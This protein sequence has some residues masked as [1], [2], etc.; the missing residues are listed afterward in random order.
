MRGPE[1]HAPCAWALGYSG[2]HGVLGSGRGPRGIRGLGVGLGAAFYGGRVMETVLFGVQPRD[3]VI[4]GATGVLLVLVALVATILPAYRAS[5]V[6]PA[7]ALRA[8]Q[9]PSRSILGGR[10]E[11]ARNSRSLHE[12][13][14]S[15]HVGLAT[16]S[17]REALDVSRLA[18][19]VCQTR[20]RA[21]ERP[22]S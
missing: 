2:W 6:D 17:Q 12:Q 7:E 9:E 22:T 13:T 5:H 21:F 14:A 18:R 19:A 11:R 10:K 15:V 4:F 1:G 20:E 8:D 3:P 16:A